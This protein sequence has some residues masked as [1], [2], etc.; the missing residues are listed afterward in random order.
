MAL[1][2]PALC[3][4]VGLLLSLAY[5]TAFGPLG[6]RAYAELQSRERALQENLRDL[7]RVNTALTE[8]L[9]S[10]SSDAETVMLLARAGYKVAAVTGRPALEGYLRSL[11]TTSIVAREELAAKGAP[12]QSERWAGGIDTVGGTVLANL[13]AQTV[14]GGAIACCGMAGGHELDIAVWPLILRNVSL[15]GVSSILTSREMR[16]EAWTRMAK[17][18]DFAALAAM[19]RTEPLTSI[20]TLAEDLLGGRSHGRVILD[21]S[22]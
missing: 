10:L 13:F 17:E 19:S 18:I 14:Y 11:G 22:A 7:E 1:A 21:V 15:L 6:L 3:F 8:E 4:Y 5:T 20:F 9:R 12:M 2:R 16:I